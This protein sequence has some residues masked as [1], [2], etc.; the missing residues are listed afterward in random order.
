MDNH[1]ISSFRKVL[2]RFERLMSNL[3][4]KNVCCSGITLPQS[5]AI[6]E[7]EELGETT[8]VHLSKNMGLDK[9]TLSRTIDG[10]VTIGLVQRHPHP[11]DRRSVLITLTDQGKKTCNEIN[12]ANDKYYSNVFQSIANEKHGDIIRCF[13][14]LVGAM[15]G[16]R[17]VVTCQSPVTTEAKD[18]ELMSS[19][20]YFDNVAGQWDTMRKDF[21][22]ESVREKAFATANIRADKL[23]ADIGAGTGFVTE[24]LIS[25]GLKVI[26]IDQSEAMLDVLRKK[27]DGI[28]CRAG[29]AESLPV[30]DETVDYV[31]ANMYLHHVEEPPAAIR[32]MARIMKTG[33]KLVITDLD[34][35][36][37]AFLREEH[38]DRWMGF[39][40]DDVTSWFTDAGLKNVQVDCV[41]QDCCSDSCDGTASAKISIFVASGTKL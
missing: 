34:E 10:L 11:S 37:F 29:R 3:Q 15:T 8:T 24:G 5:H 40:R 14:I 2:R 22:S 39:K 38:H 30:Q 25:N 13:E 28:D 1:E 41:G 18:N 17:S 4:K 36:D 23:A 6:L 20:S 33:G 7:I 35:H 26:A 27:F 21:F 12:I 32:E 9:S 31:F 16:Q 19:Q